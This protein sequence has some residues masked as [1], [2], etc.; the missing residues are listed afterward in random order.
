LKIHQGLHSLG[1]ISTFQKPHEGKVIFRE[2][3]AWLI[4]FCTK[5]ETMSHAQEATR[6]LNMFVGSK[7]F[8][9][10]CGK[11]ASDAIL[12]W[13]ANNFFIHAESLFFAYKKNL[14]CFDE[15]VNSVVEAQN[16][17]VKSVRA[18][19]IASRL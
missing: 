10:A 11:F 8:V 15:Y 12:A 13:L 14:R 3:K 17:A 19:I 5:Y 16:G 2:V 18:K 9:H 6:Q 4:L 7:H 1:V